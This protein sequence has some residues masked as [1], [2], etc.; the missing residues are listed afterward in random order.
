[1]ESM[2]ERIRNAHSPAEAQALSQKYKQLM[3]LSQQVAAKANTERKITRDAMVAYLQSKE[4]D[5]NR[6]KPFYKRS[7]QYKSKRLGNILDFLGIQTMNTS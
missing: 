4:A 3:A 2:Q 5:E 7:Y 6:L 1:M